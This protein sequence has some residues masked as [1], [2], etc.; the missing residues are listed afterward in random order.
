MRRYLSLTVFSLTLL[1]CNKDNPYK[2]SEP[3]VTKHISFKVYATKDYSGSYYDNTT[4][5]IHLSAY[6]MSLTG[7]SPQLLWDTVFS[8][9]KL[10]A[11]P[12]LDRSINIEKVFP[13]IYDS[14]ERV[15]GSFSI[16]VDTNG[17]IHQEA[18][19]EDC[20]TGNNSSLRIEAKL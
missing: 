1:S 15:R 6:K 16:K 4:A 8:K 7:A 13:N 18:M 17:S 20:N 9:Q 2:Y 19:G 3:A 14:K 11:Y 10:A 5:E 12:Q